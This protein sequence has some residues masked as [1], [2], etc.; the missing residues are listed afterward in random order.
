MEKY[1]PIEK[2]SIKQLREDIAKEFAR[3]DEIAAHGCSDP[4]WEDGMNLNL[5][6]NHII[7]GY[8]ILQERLLQESGEMQIS[9]FTPSS[10]DMSQERPVPPEV[11]DRLMV[12]EGDHA[13]RLLRWNRDDIVWMHTKDIMEMEG[14]NRR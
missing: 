13:N 9:F 14:K 1:I 4:F 6:R 10:L 2:R 3:W 8:R 7:Y 5:V 11:P 12:I